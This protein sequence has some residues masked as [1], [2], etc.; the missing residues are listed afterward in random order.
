LSK[1]NPG[2]ALEGSLQVVIAAENIP[3][4][5]AG[6]GYFLLNA[7][8]RLAEARPDW[9]FK[10]VASSSFRDLS[11]TGLP[12]VEV[13]F[14]DGT[15]LQRTAI[16]FLMRFFP[17]NYAEAGVRLLSRLVPFSLL[18]R[19]YGNLKEIYHSLGDADVIWLPHFAIG[20]GGRF[21]SL[22]NLSKARAPVLFTIHD[23]HPV[24]FPDDW[25]Q[26]AL[27]SFWN[28]FANFA[29]QSRRVV[30]HSQFQRS[31]I[32]EHLKIAPDKVVV[33]PCPPLIGETQ[34]L[35]KYSQTDM[36]D[37]LV[38]YNIS[39]PF[40]LYPGSG[41]HT[42]K[43]HT[44]LLLAWAQLKDKLGEGCPALVCTAKGHLWPAL[45]A[46]VDA[47]GL[48][49][50]VIFTGTVDTATLAKM[51]QSCAFVI[52]PSLFEGGGSGPV[53]EGLISGKPVVCSRIPPIEEQLRAYGVDL[54]NGGVTFFTPDSVDSI[55]QAVEVALQRL[56]ELETQARNTQSSLLTVPAKLWREW[57][58]FYSEQLRIVAGK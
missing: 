24:F 6:L 39:L 29:R 46:L 16:S 19:K 37:T 22:N 10:V 56:P 36:A 2:K 47:L 11:R 23:I 31:A 12:N 14:W 58:E 21:S 34:L 8:G 18:K 38:R 30:T 55:V 52:V 5:G 44:R 27:D 17:G 1:N 53:V 40:A 43:N 35:E 7:V 57:A 4:T 54:D 20:T 51:Y 15:F 3:G 48:Q 41:G 49:G 9:Q 13:I 25:P 26:D 45:K 33:T 28:G 42:H 50:N 32:L